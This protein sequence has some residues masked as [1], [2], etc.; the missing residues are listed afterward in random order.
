MNGLGV[1]ILT[2][3]GLWIHL[4]PMAMIMM[5][6]AFNTKA[7]VMMNAIQ[8]TAVPLDQDDDDYDGC[9][10]DYWMLSMLG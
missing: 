1:K 5:A 6:L 2:S 9:G 4:V 3:S 10:C 8:I 7:V